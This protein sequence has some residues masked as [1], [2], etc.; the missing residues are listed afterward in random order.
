M[1]PKA[2]GLLLTRRVTRKNSRRYNPIMTPPPM[3]PYSSQMMA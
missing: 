2:L 1:A 3:T